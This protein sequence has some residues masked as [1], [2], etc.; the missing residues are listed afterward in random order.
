MGSFLYYARAVDNTVIT[1]L[2]NIALMQ[3]APTQ[4]TKE[5]V[6]M[7][8]DYLYTYPDAKIQFYDS[9]MILNVDSDTAYLIADKAKSRVAGYYY[10]SNKTPPQTKPN[11]AMNG[12]IHIECKLL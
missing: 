7:L 11:P 9:D 2:N 6:K 10:C 8:L 4:K 12:P 1:A 5:K 3:A